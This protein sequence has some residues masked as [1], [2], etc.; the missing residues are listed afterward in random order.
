VPG[1]MRKEKV[2]EPF[3]DNH[4]CKIEVTIGLEVI[5]MCDAISFFES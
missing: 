4:H 3:S 5:K 2:F 1:E